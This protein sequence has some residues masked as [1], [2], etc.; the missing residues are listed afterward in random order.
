[1]KLTTQFR[2][3]QLGSI[4]WR[5]GAVSVSPCRLEL[6]LS[7]LAMVMFVAAPRGAAQ[8][9]KFNAPVTFPA[10]HP[11]VVS[12]GDF[13]GDGKVDLVAGDITNNDLVMLLGN[14][15]G[16]LKAPV[17]YHLTSSPR[18]IVVN[19]FNRDGKLDVAFG[20]SSPAN[21]SILLG[22]GD[23]SFEPPVNYAVAGWQITAADFNKD[24]R[25]DLV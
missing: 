4:V 18:F 12:S 22:K 8:T 17:S 10:G 11:Y 20:D 23:G 6:C 5:V 15:D 9:V 1:M 16:T 25:P 2:P 24:G 14:G 7:L 19:D 21:I 13:N 3:I